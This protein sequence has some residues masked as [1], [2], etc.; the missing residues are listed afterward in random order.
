MGILQLF[1]AALFLAGSTTAYHIRQA[2]NQTNQT[3]PVIDLDYEIYQ[4]SNFNVIQSLD[5]FFYVTLTGFQDTGRFYNFSNIRYSAKPVRFGLP[6]DPEINRTVVRDGNDGRRCPQSGPAWFFLGQKWL[7]HLVLGTACDEC[8]KPYVPV[9]ASWNLPLAAP[10]PREMEDCLFLDLFVPEKVLKSAGKGRGAAVLVWFAG[11][12]YVFGTKEENPAG[13]FAASNPRNIT[14]SDIIWISINHRMGAMGFSSGPLYQSEGGIPNLGLLDQRFAL[15]WI[16]KYVHLFGGDKDR[17]TLF[18]ESSGGGSIMHQMTAY[19]GSKGP[20]PF[21]RA[22]PQSPGWIPITSTTQQD[23]TYRLL[24][25]L[26]N[27]SSIADLKKVSEADFMRA[28][29][30][31]VGYNTTYSSFMYSPVIDGDF[32]PEI[33]TQLLAQGRFDKNVQVFYSLV[34]HEGDFFTP[35]YINTSDTLQASLVNLFPYMSSKS[36][37]TSFSSF[38]LKSIAKVARSYLERI[39]SSN[40]QRLIW[41]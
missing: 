24:L 19:G 1:G 20:V 5:E 23:D 34:A 30:L 38:K 39:V 13:L 26:T 22:V 29:S 18:G 4:A 12:G 7:S 8:F 32:T 33:P 41:I 15:E 28:N 11:G 9:G 10:D 21:R 35:P 40:L 25:N 3:L 36:H 27:S 17:V 16:Q 2:G 6:Q 31:M 37:G 14:D